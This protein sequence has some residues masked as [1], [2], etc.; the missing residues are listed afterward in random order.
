[1]KFDHPTLDK[2]MAIA[3][4]EL[5]TEVDHV[6]G[7]KVVEVRD[8]TGK[9]HKIRVE[10]VLPELRIKLLKRYASTEEPR[11]LVRPFVPKEFGTDAFLDSLTPGSLAGL[12]N[13]VVGLLLGPSA[14]TKALQG[15]PIF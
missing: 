11:D 5:A 14:V 4:R 6:N 8:K 15:K 2:A 7:F 9:T 13:V 12:S 3:S 10:I 1:M